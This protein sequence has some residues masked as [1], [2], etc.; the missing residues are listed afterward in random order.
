MIVSPENKEYIN[1]LLKNLPDPAT[2]SKETRKEITQ[3]KAIL[4]EF[5]TLRITDPKIDA[6]LNELVKNGVLTRLQRQLEHDL[7]PQ[8][9]A[10]TTH[11]QEMTA[12]IESLDEKQMLKL[13]TK[14]VV[15]LIEGA[16][17]FDRMAKEASPL[18]KASSAFQGSVQKLIRSSTFQ[19]AC[20]QKVNDL[21]FHE[22]SQE[23]KGPDKDKK[24]SALLE[25]AND[26]LQLLSAV[27]EELGPDAA[28]FNNLR[29]GLEKGMQ[30][31]RRQLS[32]A[33]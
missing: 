17:E 5:P 2:V 20:E 15:L 19:D 16:R 23:A 1:E 6:L 7:A 13:P 30:D 29:A 11:L 14:Q 22:L 21:L 33:D 9:E 31:L 26:T 27:I 12:L 32:S 24:I 10:L 3:L 28:A 4:K 8:R 18:G 25:R